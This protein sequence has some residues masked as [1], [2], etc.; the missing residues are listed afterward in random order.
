MALAPPLI[1]VCKATVRQNGALTDDEFLDL[2]PEGKM[3]V[4]KFCKNSDKAKAVHALEELLFQDVKAAKAVAQE[5]RKKLK[6]TQAKRLMDMMAKAIEYGGP[7]SVDNIDGILFKLNL[8]ETLNEVKL[9]RATL[10]ATIRQKYLVKNADGKGTFV[11]EPL[12]QLKSSLRDAIKPSDS[13]KL[14]IEELLGRAYQNAYA[15]R[16]VKNYLTPR[17]ARMVLMSSSCS[18]FLGHI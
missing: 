10:D 6:L 12:S 13:P 9:A 14:S 2:N 7:L 17:T 4:W 3:G 16:K 5:T 1:P 8:E 11:N 15:S 18:A